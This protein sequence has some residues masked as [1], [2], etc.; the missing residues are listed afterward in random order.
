MWPLLPPKCL[1]VVF[2]YTQVMFQLHFTHVAH[3]TKQICFSLT[4]LLTRCGAVQH[5]AI[6]SSFCTSALFLNT[7]CVVT[8]GGCCCWHAVVT[9]WRLCWH[10]LSFLYELLN[11][12]N[13]DPKRLSTNT[14]PPHKL[15][16]KTRS[17][18]CDWLCDFCPFLWLLVHKICKNRNYNRMRLM[19]LIAF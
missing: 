5:F 1:P 18:K 8:D 11:K 15:N 13:K 4:V 9:L 14:L 12:R 10:F 3:L 16:L 2:C 17:L 6:V 19:R 7:S